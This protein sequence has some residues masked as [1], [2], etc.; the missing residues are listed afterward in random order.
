MK[1]VK[2]TKTANEDSIRIVNHK[3]GEVIPVGL[4]IAY[5]KFEE[6]SAKDPNYTLLFPVCE[7]E[8]SR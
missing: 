4:N 3:T 5:K 2:I 1:Q 6:L 7:D 8:Q